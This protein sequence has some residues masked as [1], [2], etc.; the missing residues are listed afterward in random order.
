MIKKEWCW[1]VLIMLQVK[2]VDADEGV[3]A[4]IQFSVYETQTSGVKSLFAIHPQTG[5]LFL[6][7]PATTYGKHFIFSLKLV[8]SS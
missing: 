5:A 4:A 3:S 1:N 7:K 6:L 8:L 2:A